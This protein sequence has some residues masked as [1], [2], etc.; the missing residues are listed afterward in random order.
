MWPE[1]HRASILELLH[2]TIFSPFLSLLRVDGFA[3]RDQAVQAI[4]CSRNMLDAPRAAIGTQSAAMPAATRVSR[5]CA[6]E[7]GQDGRVSSVPSGHGGS[8]ARLEEAAEEGED[9]HARFH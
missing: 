1:L 9:A 6:I 5:P 8:A 4:V 7:R 2:K 3:R